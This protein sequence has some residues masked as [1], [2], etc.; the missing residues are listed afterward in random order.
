MSDDGLDLKAQA[1][2][3]RRTADIPRYWVMVQKQANDDPVTLPRGYRDKDK[4]IARARRWWKEQA[5]VSFD[6]NNP[7]TVRVYDTEAEP[8]GTSTVYKLMG[9][10]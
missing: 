2:F 3:K 10:E 8:G 6:P 1:E 4:A 5:H 7:T 9:Y